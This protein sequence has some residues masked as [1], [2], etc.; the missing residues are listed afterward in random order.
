MDNI[1]KGLMIAGMV[2]SMVWI[3]I[4]LA[5]I[6]RFDEELESVP[7]DEYRMRN[8]LIFGFAVLRMFGFNLDKAKHTDMMKK[9]ANLHGNYYAGY[10]YFVMLAS[11]VNFVWMTV[12][13]G[14]ILAGMAGI[15]EPAFCA[16]IIALLGILYRRME[17]KDRLDARSD[18]LVSEFPVVVS[19]MTLL[20]SAGLTM[21]EAWRQISESQEG[22]LYKEMRMVM[23][24]KENGATDEAAFGQFGER[25]G[26]REIRKFAMAMV[27]N[28]QKGSS[29]QV[30]FLK[31]MSTEM[32]ELKK[33]L[34]RKRVEDMK[35]LLLI[36]SFLIFIGILIMVLG[37]MLSGISAAFG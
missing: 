18:E 3:V 24:D 4:Y 31:D 22:A 19:K 28:M 5:H 6:N 7:Q 10:Y 26:V 9:F 32:W 33:K 37:P 16:V 13:I 36:P 25:C 1:S 12:A 11:E 23:A 27:S 30:E 21:R 34:V 29:E 14:L 8:P 2:M 35:T 17:L 20:V 15:Y